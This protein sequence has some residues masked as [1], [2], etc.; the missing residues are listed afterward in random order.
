MI[1]IKFINSIGA[2]FADL[3]DVEPDMTCGQLFASKFPGKDAG[4]Y[5][6]RVNK[7]PVSPS[8]L[9]HENDVVVVTPTKIAGA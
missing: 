2:G 3:I 5:L 6:I 4:S 7:S 1:K 8:Q 9:L